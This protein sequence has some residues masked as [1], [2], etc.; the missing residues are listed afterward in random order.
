MEDLRVKIIT[1]IISAVFGGTVTGGITY[2]SRDSHYA[3]KIESITSEK[4]KL[5]NLLSNK[6]KEIN[7]LNNAGRIFTEQIQSLNEKNQ[8]LVIEFQ[9]LNNKYQKC[10]SSNGIINEIGSIDLN[11][12]SKQ[13][14]T[15]D[16]LEFKLISSPLLIKFVRVSDRGPVFEIAGCINYLMLNSRAVPSNSNQYLLEEGNVLKIRF[17]I[18]SC[19]SNSPIEPNN[20]EEI[21]I[22]LLA[23]NVEDQ[24]FQIEYFRDFL[25]K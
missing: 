6:E 19:E 5:E 9:D 2:L 10:I 23:F 4:T 18:N 15:G 13:F 1:A 17:T 12:Y 16:N 21:Q 8:S 25:I 11:K 14:R 7:N 22:K 24:T 20:L 3:D